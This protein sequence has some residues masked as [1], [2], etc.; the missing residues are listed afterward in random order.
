MNDKQLRA[1][2]VKELRAGLS[3]LSIDVR[4]IAGNQPTT[5]GRKDEGLYFFQIADALAGWQARSYERKLGNNLDM[6]DRQVVETSF[7]VQA[8]VI[9][10]PASL[11]Q[12]TALD[13]LHAA[14]MI[15]A[16][17]PFVEAMQRDSVGVQRP[18]NIR[19]PY[20]TNDRDQ[21]EMSPSFDF[22]LSHERGIITSI[23][24]VESAVLDIHRL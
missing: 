2:I 16:S 14:K 20:F 24:A 21:F 11:A 19:T 7:Q 6:E 22:T 23:K 5:Q 3:R 12:L 10:D 1:L 18:S 9:D 15:I 4:V 8:L 17:L 13:V